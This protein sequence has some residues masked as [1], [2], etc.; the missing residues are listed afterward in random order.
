MLHK[1]SPI[2]LVDD[3]VTMR[4]MVKDVLVSDGYTN[5]QSAQD[6]KDALVK[7]KRALTMG[8]MYK[9]IFLDW[10]MPEMDGLSF[11]KICRGDL[12]LKD[13]AIVMLTAVSDQ[14]NVVK[15]LSNGATSYIT[16]PVSAATLL[17][18]LKQVSDW[19]MA[20]RSA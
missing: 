19:F 17:K 14:K 6:G 8:E 15:A 3:S 13:V 16:K 4:E 12:G 7:L 1:D 5:I 10:N 20:R 11:L 2:L 9:V 18:K